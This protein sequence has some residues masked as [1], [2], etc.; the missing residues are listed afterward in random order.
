[1]ANAIQSLASIQPTFWPPPVSL[2]ACVWMPNIAVKASASTKRLNA[3]AELATELRL[4][5]AGVL[6]GAL[7]EAGVLLDTGV[8]LGALLEAGVLEAPPEQQPNC[9]QA[10]SMAPAP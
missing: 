7:L 9:T 1:M 4:L 6:L 10:V 2:V 5:D 8:L 3:G